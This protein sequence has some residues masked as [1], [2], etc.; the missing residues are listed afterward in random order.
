MTGIPAHVPPDR[1]QRVGDVFH[2]Y[3]QKCVAAVNVAAGCSITAGDELLFV[4]GR[5]HTCQCTVRSM[6]VN[7]NPKP[8]VV[9]PIAVGIET[10]RSIRRQATV[11]R[12]LPDPPTRG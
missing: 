2:F 7:H 5:Q 8:N 9:G 3:T 11:Y 12:I 4:D 10:D 6:Q 1:L